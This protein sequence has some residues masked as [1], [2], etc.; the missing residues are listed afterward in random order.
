MKELCKRGHNLAETAYVR[1]SGA[2]QCG[3]CIKQRKAERK[4]EKAAQSESTPA[5]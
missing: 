4:A 5:A 2:R 3:E 1:P